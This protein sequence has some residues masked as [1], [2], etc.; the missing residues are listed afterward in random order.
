MSYSDLGDLAQNTF[1]KLENACEIM[2]KIFYH[3]SIKVISSKG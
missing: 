1:S 2:F 3:I